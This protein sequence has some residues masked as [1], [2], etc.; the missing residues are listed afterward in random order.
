MGLMDWLKNQQIKQ[1]E[2]VE[3]IQRERREKKEKMAFPDKEIKLPE[4]TKEEQNDTTK[5]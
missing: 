4:P 3:R 1:I 5:I 2:T